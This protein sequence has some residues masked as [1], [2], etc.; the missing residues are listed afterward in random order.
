MKIENKFL[1][2]PQI[3]MML[4]LLVITTFISI[5]IINNIFID[6]EEN[7]VSESNIRLNAAVNQEISRIDTLTGDWAAWDDSY[8]FAENLNPEFVDINFNEGYL[9]TIDFDFMVY[10]NKDG[11]VLFIRRIDDN[12]EDT[13]TIGEFDSINIRDNLEHLNAQND[14]VGGLIKIKDKIA[15]VAINRITKSD[16]SGDDDN[17]LM[18][19]KYLDSQFADELSQILH[20]SVMIYN[21]DSFNFTNLEARDGYYLQRKSTFISS[22]IIVNDMDEKPVAVLT[23]NL[24]R[25]I[26]NSGIRAV[27]LFIV[28]V[29]LFALIFFIVAF[30]AGRILFKKIINQINQIKNS[31]EKI[32]MGNY[33]FERIESNDEIGELS[34]SFVKMAN[35]LKIAKQNVD[36]INSKLEN[37]VKHQTLQLNN[38]LEELEK[39]KLAIYNMMDDLRESNKNLKQTDVA[40]SEFL[41][42]VSHELKTPLTAM[43]AHLDVLDDLKD[44][45]SEQEM[46]SL[47]A[48]RRN[49]SQLRLLI[50]NILEISRM[51][52]GKFELARNKLDI[53]KILLD[54]TESLEVLAKQKNIKLIT[55]IDELPQFEFDDTRISEVMNNLITNAIKFTENG[56]III[57]ARK[58]DD[59]VEVK[60]KDTGIGIPEDKLK[61][62][63][64]KFYQVDAS[65]SRRYGGT[66]LGLSI[67]KKI[68]EAH[69]GKISVE[70]KVGEGSTFT[71]TLPI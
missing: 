37:E 46:H 31:A 16:G 47:E 23:A 49:A 1:V 14:S 42:I 51:E 29:F 50:S 19:G 34:E 39:T 26:F 20:F 8:F 69:G 9:D 53:K 58:L 57:E 55:K 35:Q 3:I 41:N 56:K 27:K 36:E 67:T 61:N 65:L 62:M 33:D 17:Y 63:F 45:L 13:S 64:E 21:Y 68:V 2:V 4:I 54:V 5:Y 38:K 18:G 11:D 43:V 32:S 22:Y 66:G 60:V 24:N 40:K 52:S 15:L 28:V 44:N 59:C 70:S 48:I 71:F 25:E 30:F 6:L 12:G 10:T 7:Q